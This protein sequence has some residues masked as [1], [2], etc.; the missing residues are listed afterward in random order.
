[1]KDIQ[2]EYWKAASTQPTPNNL[3]VRTK[4]RMRQEAMRSPKIRWSVLAPACALAVLVTASANLS[5]Y[6]SALSAED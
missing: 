2:A 6:T 1:M 5:L 4:E 3:F